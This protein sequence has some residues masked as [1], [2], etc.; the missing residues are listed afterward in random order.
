MNYI[1]EMIIMAGIKSEVFLFKNYAP[2]VL[3]CEDVI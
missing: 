2:S 3:S 1:F